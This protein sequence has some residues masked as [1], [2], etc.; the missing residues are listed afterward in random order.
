AVQPP[1][2]GA[3]RIFAGGDS[4]DDSAHVLPWAIGEAHARGAEAFLFLG[5]ME[6]T[7]QLDGSF[8]R[9]IAALD[10]IPLYPVLGNHE[11]RQFGFL[12]IGQAGAERSFAARFLGTPRT[13]VRSALPGRVVY[14]VSLPG[15]VH[16]V[17]LDNVS[18]SGFG[19]E[20]LAWLAADL[21]AATADHEV[22]HVVVGMHKPLAH[23]GVTQHCMEADG[24][25]AVAD[26]DAALDLFARHHVALILASHVH[27]FTRF[28]QAGIPTYVTGGLGAPLTASGPDH[29]FHHVLQLDVTDAGIHVEVLRYAG[30]P[31]MA[32]RDGDDGD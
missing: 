10:P 17:A 20:Q 28:T 22:R 13:P 6:L 11:I 21:D 15:G 16:F 1:P 9:E 5:D 23:N 14:S 31:V 7:P 2:P 25:Q 18:Q 30:P 29:A 26:S 4:R 24:P 27:Q 12:A 8:A 19:A 32:T 3:V